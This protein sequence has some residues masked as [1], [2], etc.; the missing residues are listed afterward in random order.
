MLNFKIRG[1]LPED[2][3]SIIALNA[4]EVV[5]TS[6]MDSA[7]I[8]ALHYLSSYHKVVEHNGRVVGFLLAM[9]SDDKYINENFDWFLNRYSQFVYIDRIVIDASCKGLG[10]GR[11]LYNDLFAFAERRGLQVLCCE[12]NLSPVNESSKVFHTKMGFEQVGERTYT[13]SDKVV[14][15][16][17]TKI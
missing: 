6:P 17:A 16:Q 7:K 1:A 12:Y 5:W 4:A 11:T 14:S 9:C 8:S 10:I 2:F 15:M 13:N 3:Q